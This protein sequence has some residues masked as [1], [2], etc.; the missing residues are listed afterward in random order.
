[1]SPGFPVKYHIIGKKKIYNYFI[2]S[3]CL[4]GDFYINKIG[5]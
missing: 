3:V 2:G 4:S 5:M 1:M